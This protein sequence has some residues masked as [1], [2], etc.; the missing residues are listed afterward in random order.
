M[1][2][3]EQLQR[4]CHQAEDGKRGPGG[5]G[6]ERRWCGVR[7]GAPVALGGHQRCGGTPWSLAARAAHVRQ[8]AT[9]RTSPGADAARSLVFAGHCWPRRIPWPAI[10]RPAACRRACLGPIFGGF[11]ILEGNYLRHFFIHLTFCGGVVELGADGKHGATGGGR[12]TRHR[13]A[14]PLHEGAE[15]GAAPGQCRHGKNLN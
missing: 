11:L 9:T 3:V 15:R 14:K 1:D 4:L 6:N 10:S 12:G 7:R 13:R 2:G 8:V 5:A